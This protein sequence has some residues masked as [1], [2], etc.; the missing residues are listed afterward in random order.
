M[1]CIVKLLRKVFMSLIRSESVSIHLLTFAAPLHLL[2]YI[3]NVHRLI[4]LFGCSFFLVLLIFIKGFSDSICAGCN[5]Q[6]QEQVTGDS[7]VQTGN[8][9]KRIISCSIRLAWFVVDCIFVV[10]V[11]GLKE[12]CKVER[13][14]KPNITTRI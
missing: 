6:L 10:V 4:R 11:V 9:A 8:T 7:S 5:S 12:L 14:N 2:G 1:L 3:I 13:L